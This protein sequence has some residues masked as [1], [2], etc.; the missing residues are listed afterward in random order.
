MTDRQSLGVLI[1]MIIALILL[2]ASIVWSDSSGVSTGNV[3]KKRFDWNASSPAPVALELKTTEVHE[4]VD[5]W[6]RFVEVQKK[7]R[8]SL[9]GYV[10]S[11]R[12]GDSSVLWSF[13]LLCLGYG[14]VHAIG[15]G[16]GKSVVAGY[17]L[18]RKGSWWQGVLLGLGITLAHVMSAVILLYVLFG[19]ARLTIFPVFES[20]RLNVERT[21][22][23]LLMLAGLTIIV[24]TIKNWVKPHHHHGF[25]S[26]ARPKEMIGLALVTGLVP[27]PAVAL[28]VFFCLL[29]S[30]VWQGLAGAAFIGMGMAITNVSFG[31]LAIAT[32]KGLDKGFSAMSRSVI[33][34]QHGLSL[35]G[36][37]LVLFVGLALFL[38]L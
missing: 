5:L 12:G 6:T 33:Y 17:F 22:Y 16:H 25:E 31:V 19:L 34:L 8:E 29:N 27:C 35:L 7:M 21:S 24:L 1:S 9:T 38:K 11:M 13:L 15:P 26:V 14:V 20:I 30:L 2:L 4:S 18:A 36:G 28:V 37:S 10:N 23:A 3:A 32:R